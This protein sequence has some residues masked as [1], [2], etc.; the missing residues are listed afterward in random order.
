LRSV[1]IGDSVTSIGGYAFDGCSAYIYNEYDNAYYLGNEDNP[2]LWLIEA[3]DKF[4]TSCT[5]NGNTK[6]IYEYAFS[7]CKGLTSINIPNSVTS[8]GYRAFYDCTSIKSVH[9]NDIASWCNIEFG[10]SD[11]NPLGYANNLYINGELL[12]ELVI[13]DTIT[14][15]KDYAFSNCTS[16]KSINIPSSVTSIGYRAFYDCTGLT[17]VT[18]PSSVTSIGDCAF[19]WCVNLTSVTIG[20]G[21]TSIGRIAFGYCTS[22]TSITIPDSVTSIGESAFEGCTI[23]TSV[24]YLGA[25]EQWCNIEFGGSDANPVYYTKKLCINGELLE[26]LTIPNTV[27]EIKN[28]TF[29]GC[30]SL[31]SITIPDSV[32]SIGDCAFLWCVNLTS[33]T[34]GEGVTS[35]GNSAFSGCTLITYNEYDNAYYIGNKD[36]PYVVL[37][38]AKNTAITSCTINENTKVIYG[39]AFLDCTSLKSITIPDSVT[40]IGG[41]A[42]LDCTS[43]KSITIP[44]NVTSIGR[45]AFDGCTALTEINFNAKAMDNLSEDDNV[46]SYAGNNGV[47]I[48]VTIGKDVTKIPAYLFYSNSY[49]SSY[50]PNI[51]SV[52]F[53][54]DSVCESIGGCA[55]YRCTRLKSITI[56]D[57]VTS[58]GG[59]AFYGCTSLTSITIPDSVTSIGESAFEGCTSLTSVTIGDSVTTIGV[60]AFRDCDNLTSI[61]IPNSVT[62]IGGTAFYGCTKLTSVNYLGTIEQWCNIQFDNSYATPL[63]YANNL[64]ING[65]LLTELV[66]PDTV[67]KINDY[68]FYR[69]T[70][71]KSITIPDSVTSIGGSAFYGCTSLTSITIPDSVT[72]IGD[73]MFGYCTSLTSI[74]IPDSVTSI[75]KYA[76]YNCKSL[77]TIYYSG[78]RSLWKSLPKGDNWSAGV[79]NLTI[80]YD[81]TGE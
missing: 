66:I 28:Y 42:F 34:I 69:C 20:E 70:R 38:K 30:T 80:I 46:F 2:Y 25:I 56:P 5:I 15:I 29:H 73:F 7:E 18:I 23:L 79:E 6:F 19:L 32:T 22:L 58:I 65:E 33:V 75:G 21:V 47:G 45:Y 3:K 72:S 64:Y 50:L 1:T 60:N 37:I 8:I 26:E 62:S 24:N 81:Y 55:F 71:L 44:N 43:L 67:T 51:T 14:E 39:G 52:V 68:A 49:T 61:T 63:C 57:S 76:F 27:T 40:S 10:V 48:K 35:I 11:A 54:E 17:S 9:I 12:T 13:P 77:K 16:L 74:T 31:T 53:E 4:I 78:S 41:S 36:N 59:S